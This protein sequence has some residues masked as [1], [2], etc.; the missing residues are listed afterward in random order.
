MAIALITALPF[1]TIKPQ[2]HLVVTSE[3]TVGRMSAADIEGTSAFPLQPG[4]PT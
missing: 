4:N 3:V 2:H 1:V